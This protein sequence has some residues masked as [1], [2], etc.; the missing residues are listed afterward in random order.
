[1]DALW[2]EG[3]TDP[4]SLARARLLVTAHGGVAA[5]ERLIARATRCAR[6][7]VASLPHGG[8]FRDLLDSLVLSLSQR[9]S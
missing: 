9:R 2:S 6:R 3:A 5:T 1:M 7:M 8:G 4:V